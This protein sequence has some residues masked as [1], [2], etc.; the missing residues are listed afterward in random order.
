MRDKTIIRRAV[1]AIRHIPRFFS[2]TEPAVRYNAV[3]AK[4]EQHYD[5]YPN[6][7]TRRKEHSALNYLTPAD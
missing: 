1:D 5:A 6:S 2:S 3:L 4:W 7:F